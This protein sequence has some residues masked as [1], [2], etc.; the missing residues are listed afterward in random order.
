MLELTLEEA[1]VLELMRI[2]KS[3]KGRID[4]LSLEKLLFLVA[5]GEF[6]SEGKVVG[7]RV[8]PRLGVDYRIYFRGVHSRDVHEIINRLIDKGLVVVKDNTIDIVQ[9]I[10]APLPEDI[11]TIVKNVSR[12]AELSPRELEELTNKLLGIEDEAIKALIFNAKVTR[13]LKVREEAKR[14]REKGLL[15]DV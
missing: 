12:Y 8:F 14:L 13:L 6:N 9:M 1:V 4:R 10:A 7:L 15:I 2:L 11:A 3:S 5:H